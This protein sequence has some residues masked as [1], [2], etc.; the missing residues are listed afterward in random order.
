M[1]AGGWGADGRDRFDTASPLYRY[2]AR[3]T[4]LRRE[5]RVFSRGTPTVLHENAAGPGAFAY[6]MAHDG[7]TALVA[8]NSADAPA[9]LDNLDTGL[10][11]GTR[12][13]PLFAIDGEAPPLVVDGAGRIDVVLP[14]RAGLA[15]LAD[16]APKA[17]TVAAKPAAL[18]A[19]DVIDAAPAAGDFE[20]TGTAHGVAAFDLVV[21]GELARAIPVRPGADGR[22]RARIDTASMIDPAIAHRVVAWSAAHGVA[23]APRSFRVAR[24]W[25]PLAQVDDPAGDDHGPDGRY[26]Y[27]TDPSWG[28][29]RQ[30]DLRAARAEGSGGALRLALD[31]HRVTRSWSPANGFDHVAFGIYVGFPGEPGARELPHRNARMPDDLRWQY[32]LRAHGWS[33]AMFGAQGAQARHEGTPLA[34]GATLAVDLPA[35][36]VTFTFPA[37]ALGNRRSL[38]GARVY[39]TTW[40]YDGGWRGLTMTGGS[41]TFGGGDGARDPLLMDELLLVVP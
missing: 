18:L 30:M 1:F 38:S 36:R 27:P 14:A 6:R 37:A 21:D 40:D 23:S 13:R 5:N 3:A 9:L 34:A 10:A 4:A 41:H 39:V 32:A 7:A 26:R 19:V 35:N 15:W 2:L 31:L 24:R 22:W 25:A 33:N 16:D 17:A 28:D 11:P 8:F 29:N 12:L 20:V